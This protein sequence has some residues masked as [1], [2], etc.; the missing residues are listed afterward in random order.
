VRELGKCN[1]GAT[2]AAY[3]ELMR[4]IKFVVDTKWYGLKMVPT[5]NAKTGQWT[6]TIYTDS[7][8]AGDKDNRI[9]ITGYIVFLMGVAV[10]WKSQAQR[11]VSLSSSEAEYYALAEA[12]KDVKFVVKVL[13]SMGIPVQLP[14]IIR[15]DNMG[16]I[17]MSQNG[18]ATS[19]TRH[20]DTRY[21]FVREFVMS[22]FIKI[23]F[24]RSADNVADPFTKNV[25]GEVY[26]SHVK[27]YVVDRDLFFAEDHHGQ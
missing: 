18:S 3:K 1:N 11:S 24:V 10:L 17:F 4:T 2:M 21:H 22:G 5:Y 6:I 26:E 27:E 23:I 8:W 25:T 13:I 19:R 12:A 9:S 7:D 20:V 14:V 16:A 15:V